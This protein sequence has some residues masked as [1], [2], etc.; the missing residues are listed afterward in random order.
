[1]MARTADSDVRAQVIGILERCPS[2]SYLSRSAQRR[3]RRD[4]S[5]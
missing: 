5:G 2:G 3:L 4:A 1:M